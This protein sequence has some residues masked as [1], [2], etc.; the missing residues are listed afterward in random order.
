MERTVFRQVLTFVIRNYS[1]LTGR[2]R[3]TLYDISIFFLPTR[4]I[5]YDPNVDRPKYRLANAGKKVYASIAKRT[6]KCSYESF[7]LPTSVYVSGIR[8][9]IITNVPTPYKRC[10]G[11]P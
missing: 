11:N 10:T 5:P 3:R 9:S 6:I 1:K 4:P 8:V 2:F 7:G